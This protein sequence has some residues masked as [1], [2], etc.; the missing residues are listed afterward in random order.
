MMSKL[1]PGAI[2]ETLFE[3]RRGINIAELTGA[4][5]FEW[6][7][8]ALLTHFLL[9]NPTTFSRVCPFDQVKFAGR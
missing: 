7:K 9:P 8:P 2:E 6:E 1:D 4:L 3:F 5:G